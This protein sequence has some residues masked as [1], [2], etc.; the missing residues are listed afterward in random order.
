M[1]GGGRSRAKA[2]PAAALALLLTGLVASCAS[3]AADPTFS[4]H[5][6][7]GKAELDGYR[8]TVTRYGH[9]REGHAIAIFVTEPF[10]RSRHVKLDDPS[11]TPADAVDVLKLN[12]VREFRTGIYDYHTM[13]SLFAASADLEPLKL[14][15]TAAEWCGQVHERLDRTDSGWTQRLDSYF[16]GESAE[17]ELDAP[18]GGLLEEELF[19]RLRGLHAPFLAPGA[20]R[21]VPFLPGSFHRRLAHRAAG[22]T[23]ARIERRASA[24]RV[25]VPAGTFSADLYVVRTGD[26]REGRFHVERA[27]PRR[28]VRWS[29]APAATGAARDAAETAELT[30]STRLAYW[31]LNGPDGERHLRQLGLAPRRR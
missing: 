19:L 25:V 20:E 13:S 3:Q 11:R 29:W 12:L 22:W 7:D 27:H 31:R 15:F 10:S 23:T 18:P 30:G 17:G 16:E 24:E 4:A 28:I 5:W 9:P 14:A 1:T 2:L 21:T 26:G 6:H 8:Y